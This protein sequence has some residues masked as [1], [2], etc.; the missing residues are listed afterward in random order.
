MHRFFCSPKNI[1]SHEIQIMDTEELHHMK[2]VMRLKNKDKIV[3][4][5]GQGAKFVC[6][7]K[8]LDKKAAKLEI[9]EK[10]ICKRSEGYLNITV[11]CALLKKSKI[12]FIVEK[13]TEIGVDRIIL[14]NTERT[15]VKFKDS[16]KKLEKLNRVCESALKQSG[17]LFLPKLEYFDFSELIEFKKSEKFDLAIMPNLE[18][19]SQNIKEITSGLCAKNILIAIGPE[20]DF[21]KKEIEIAKKAG[22]VSVSLGKNVLKVDTAAIVAAGFLKLQSKDK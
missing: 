7:I 4:L 18:E 14:L 15:E 11:A 1:T 21:S 17:N 10:H 16:P 13:L 22:F 20:G 5:D 19:S 12:D 9:I 2:N 6:E 3:V 8:Q